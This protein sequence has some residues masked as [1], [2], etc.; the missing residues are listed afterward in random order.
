MATVLSMVASSCIPPIAIT[1]AI[2]LREGSQVG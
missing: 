2:K 1:A